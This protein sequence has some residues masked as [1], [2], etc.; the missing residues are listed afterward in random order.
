M[1]T[2]NR[3][4]VSGASPFSVRNFVKLLARKTAYAESDKRRLH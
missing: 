3:T 2:Y 1:Q 4:E